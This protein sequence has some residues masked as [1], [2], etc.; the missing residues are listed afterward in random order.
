MFRQGHGKSIQ[1]SIIMVLNEFVQNPVDA[2]TVGPTMLTNGFG[3]TKKVSLNSRIDF[4]RFRPDFN[5]RLDLVNAKYANLNF[6]M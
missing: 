4:F 3:V 2:T 6:E 1:Y 5:D